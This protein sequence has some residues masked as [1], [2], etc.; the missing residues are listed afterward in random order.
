MN[1]FAKENKKTREYYNQDFS[2]INVLFARIRN[3]L[4]TGEKFDISDL[5]LKN[6][7]DYNPEN[8]LYITIFE[9]FKKEL[10]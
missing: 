6:L 7:I 9:E 8:L 1:T 3:S 5:N 4:F 10:W 2:Q